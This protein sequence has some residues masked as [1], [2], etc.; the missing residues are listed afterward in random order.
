MRES[1]ALIESLRRTAALGT[2]R[3]EAGDSVEAWPA[4]GYAPGKLHELYARD[5]DDGAATSGFAVA[6][7]ILARALP[8]LWIVPDAARRRGGRLLGAGLIELG[9]DPGALITIAVADEAMLLR[10]A[11]DAARCPGVGTLVVESHGPAPRIDLTATRRLML[12][13]EASGV[14]I[15]SLRIGADPVPSAAATR[16]GIAA[17]PSAA[18]TLPGPPLD[19]PGH[20]A[21]AVELLRQ[22]G[23]PAGMR[24]QMEWNR[25]AKIFTP[26]ANPHADAAPLSGAGLPL[27]VDR[28]AARDAP[29]P[30]RRTG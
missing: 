28:A 12:A 26:L 3:A 16:W 18:L 11:A 13:A 8:L 4:R 24:W 2:V 23:G 27:A 20:P 7:A 29:A 25:D 30:L 15:L 22:R 14:T 10:A 1:V 6:L 5:A 19:A 17:L 21:F 9:L